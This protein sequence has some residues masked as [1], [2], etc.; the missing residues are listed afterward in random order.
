MPLVGELPR[1]DLSHSWPSLLLAS[2]PSM[3]THMWRQTAPVW[4]GCPLSASPAHHWVEGQRQEATG[5]HHR[6]KLMAVLAGE[7][8]L[9]SRREQHLSAPAPSLN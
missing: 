4:E 3:S 7:A 1:S 2:C 6:S 8:N 5:L 9:P